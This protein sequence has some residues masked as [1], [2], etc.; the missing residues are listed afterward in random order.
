[1]RFIDF[2]V[3]GFVFDFWRFGCRHK[4]PTGE[5][6]TV[7]GRFF[8]TCSFWRVR[9]CVCIHWFFLCFKSPFSNAHVF[10]ENTHFIWI[11]CWL[12]FHCFISVFLYIFDRSVRFNVSTLVK[13]CAVVIH[14]IFLPLL[15]SRTLFFVSFSFKDALPSNDTPKFC[16]NTMIPKKNRRFCLYLFICHEIEMHPFVDTFKHTSHATFELLE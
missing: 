16:A 8:S 6:A 3:K 15:F 12:P 7:R 14:L 1:M 11:C 2:Q 10:R 5:C 4:T 13:L 9:L